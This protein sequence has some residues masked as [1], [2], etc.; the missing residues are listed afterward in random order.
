MPCYKLAYGG[1]QLFWNFY[2]GF[3]LSG[4]GCLVFFRSFALGLLLVE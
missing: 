4:K 1:Q 3:A 2:D